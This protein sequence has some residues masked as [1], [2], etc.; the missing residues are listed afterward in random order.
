MSEL[1]TVYISNGGSAAT[2]LTPTWQSLKN[3]ATGANI[4]PQPTFAEVGGGFYRFT[5]DIGVGIQWCGVIDGGATITEPSERY[6]P[7]MAGDSDLAKNTLV[8]CTPVYDETSDTL[9][10]FVFMLRDGQIVT[11]ASDAEVSVYDSGHTLLFTVSGSSSTNGVFV[12]SKNTPGIDSGE[13]YYC[14]GTITVNTIDFVSV[15]TMLTLD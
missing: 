7:F 2:G 4:T 1:R 14:V 11:T 3:V 15:E 12:L 6:V 9:T 8:F 10:F 13:G 5:V